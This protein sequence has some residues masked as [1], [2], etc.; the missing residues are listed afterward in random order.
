[1]PINKKE[2]KEYFLVQITEKNKDIISKILKNP[3]NLSPNYEINFVSTLLFSF[4][5]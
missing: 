5:K 4:V 2:E 3:S 1:M